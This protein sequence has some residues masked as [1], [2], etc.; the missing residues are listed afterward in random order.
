MPSI[1]TV[2]VFQTIAPTPET[3]QKS[4]ALISQ[5]GTI[6]SPGT[7]SLLTQLSDL[8]PLLNGSKALSTLTCTATL[9][10]A[11]ASVAHG[12]TV[13]D[14]ILLTIAGVT[15]AAYNGTYQCTVTTTT[16]FTYRLTSTPASASIPGAYTVEDVSELLAM[17]TTFFSNGS[18]QAISVLEF[19]PGS[20]DD[21]VAALSAYITA[22]PNSAYTPGSQGFFY[23]YL[24]P[25]FWDANSNFMAL[26]QQFNSTTARTYFWITTTL[27]TY[28]LYS[29]LDKCA[30]LLI[31]SPQLSAYP[32]NALT[33]ISATG[34]IITGTTT[35]AHGVA[36]GSWFTIQG[37]TPSG[38]NGTFQALPGTTGSTLVYQVQAAPGAET[39]LGVLQAS[40]FANPAIPATEFSI[41]AAL[42]V[43]LSYDPNATNKVTPFAFSFLFGVTPFPTR[44]NNAL[45]T[46]LK[47]A[48]VNVVGTGAEGG[49]SDAILLWGTTM[50]GQDFTYWYSVDWIQINIDISIAN[51]II[52]G[53]NNPINP[54]YYNQDGINRLQA[55]AAQVVASGVAF[56][57]VLGQP[58][59]TSLDAQTLD[60][61]INNGK[62]ANLSV[63]NALPFLLY[64]KLNPG[65]Y[66][67]G[68][69]GGFAVVYVPA[70]GFIHI[71]FN[72]N[73]SQF[74]TQ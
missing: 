7:S 67:I 52:N 42:H 64:S 5:G 32:Q 45:L 20:A 41:A 68:N 62:Y 37:V 71:V 49:I 21:G 39:V 33:A 12:F 35:S 38:Y 73:V 66:K 13:G 25:R 57:L 8:T 2:N 17:A 61:G 53:S 6:T 60:D 10:T 51:A 29:D 48:A 22:N 50:D 11:T 19:G 15:P 69:Y 54:L 24:V 59:Q 14:T 63:I 44:G 18:N 31:E 56:G 65:D 23:H 74:V 30:I 26:L 40:F 72:V 27:A 36:V 9:V 28:Q 58:V 70:R 55:V 4:G 43:V 1:V 46:T 47:G 16:A 34:T 3:L